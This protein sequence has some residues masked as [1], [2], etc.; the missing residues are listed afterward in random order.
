VQT[1]RIGSLDV[2][3]VGIGC[4]NFGRRLDADGT[5]AVVH[6]AL[7]AGINFFDTADSYG[8]DGRSEDLMG[9]AFGKRCGEAIIA[10]KFGW[11][12]DEQ[13]RGAH[14]DYVKQSVEGSL[15]RLQI[16][17]IDLY[18]LHKPDPSVPIADTLGAMN[19]LV[20]AGKVRE[21]G[22]SNFSA[23][24]L[25][26]A[27]A[28]RP[29]DAARFVSVQN[30]YSMLQR[31]QEDSV[32]PECER[33]GIAFLPYSPL[34]N[35]LLT[36][37]FRQGQPVPEGTRIAGGGPPAR[38][39]TDENLAVVEKLIAFAEARG[40]TA[41]DLAFAWLLSRRPVASVIAGAMSPEQVQANAAAASWEMSDAELKEVDAILAGAG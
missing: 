24:Q 12:I 18:Q 4:N 30:Q 9:R 32:L 40:H 38:Y 21:I 36:G 39:L 28:A 31:E 10:T 37:K 34:A 15:R 16:D 29:S 14:P 35:G 8:G 25:R 20:Q 33:L 23:E 22:C 26:E 41:L 5:A 1:R 27:E 19:D 7:N 17:Y 11:E 3:V 6:A 13:R 2:S